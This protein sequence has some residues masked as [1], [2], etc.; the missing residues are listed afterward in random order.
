[1]GYIGTSFPSHH[2]IDTSVFKAPLF[3]SHSVAVTMY[4]EPFMSDGA[5]S[6][7]QIQRK[8]VKYI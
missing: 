6:C 5:M 1:M 2:K 8:S 4:L 3:N 7:R